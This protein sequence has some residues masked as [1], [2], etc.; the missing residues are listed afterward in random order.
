M[1]NT[2]FNNIEIDNVSY[3]DG[4]F[5]GFKESTEKNNPKKKILVASRDAGVRSRLFKIFYSYDLIFME[6]FSIDEL[7]FQTAMNPDI[8]AFLIE[9]NLLR[10]GGTQAIQ[11]L[12]LLNGLN[13]PF[14]S[15]KKVDLDDKSLENQ[16]LDVLLTRY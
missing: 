9:K 8:A 10:R 11:A 5:L 7:H 15:F 16:V 14:I 3:N 13:V 4:I 2:I 12:S 6:S 1:N